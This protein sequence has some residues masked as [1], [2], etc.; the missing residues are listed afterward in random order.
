MIDHGIKHSRSQQLIDFACVFATKAHGEQKRKYTG[1]PYINHP[2]EVA[3]I[4]ASV[5]DDCEAI[6]AA[7]L[8]DVVEDT[9]VT[10]QQISDAGFG[11]TIAKLVD[12]L[13]D[14]S[15]PSDGN[16]RQRKALDREHL[17]KA[18]PRAQTVKLADLISNSRDIMKHDPQF[19][20]VYMHE[21][22]LLLFVLQ[23][24]DPTLYVEACQIVD[25]FFDT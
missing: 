3:Q 15:R 9:P 22:R 8:H 10:L 21:K 7:F 12:E 13:T 20:R 1:E 14:V 24:G 25:D 19:A 17:A 5:T 2:V 6:C 11:P 16:R 4:V 18:S 23:D